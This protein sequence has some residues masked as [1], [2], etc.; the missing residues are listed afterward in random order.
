[1]RFLDTRT[2]GVLDYLIGAVLIA[3]PWLFGFALHGVE[4][5]APVTLGALLI[6]YSMF[7][8]YEFSVVRRIPMR[9]HLGLDIAGGAV[10]AASPWLFGFS[11]YVFVPHLAVGLLEAGAAAVTQKHPSRRG[12]NAAHSR[13]HPGMWSR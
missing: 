1:M 4:T 12:M 7:T 13:S 5:W 10:L 9:I 8:D 2:H 6:L 3:A 11:E